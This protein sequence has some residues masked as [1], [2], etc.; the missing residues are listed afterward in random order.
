MTLPDTYRSRILGS[1]YGMLVG[2]ALGAPYEF[3]R[4]DSYT[5]SPDYVE[6]KT[7][8]VPLPLGAWTDDSSMALC[9]LESLLE[10]D[11]EW[12]AAH[13]VEKWVRWMRQGYMSVVDECFDIGTC[14]SGL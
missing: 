7:F 3:K 14:P 13:C 6:C 11:G 12:D 8:A 9:L 4:R 10:K 1:Y 5:V 2:D